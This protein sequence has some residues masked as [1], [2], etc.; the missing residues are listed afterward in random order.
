MNVTAHTHT[1][2]ASHTDLYT[3]DIAR[4]WSRSL[5]VSVSVVRAVIT[6]N[7]WPAAV[8]DEINK[9]QLR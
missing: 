7:Y 5:A 4:F 2:N 8:T 3:N 9:L 1:H 6:C